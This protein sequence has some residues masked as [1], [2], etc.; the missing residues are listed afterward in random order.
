MAEVRKLNPPV[1]HSDNP[2]FDWNDST[3]KDLQ[4]ISPCIHQ[5]QLT[6]HKQCSTT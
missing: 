1:H 2:K 3:K 6:D 5:V 4:S